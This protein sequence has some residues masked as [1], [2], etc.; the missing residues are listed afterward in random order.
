MHREI[1]MG[2]KE[3]DGERVKRE[4]LREMHREIEIRERKKKSDGERGA[5][6]ETRKEI[7]IGGERKRE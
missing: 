6:R 7:E 3:S 1:N 2:G 4:E 5:K